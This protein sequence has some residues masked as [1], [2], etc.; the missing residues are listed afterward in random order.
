MSSFG[1]SFFI[2]FLPQWIFSSMFFIAFIIAFFIGFFSESS[3]N[4]FSSISSTKTVLSGFIILLLVCLLF[5][6]RILGSRCRR[7]GLLG[8][9]LFLGFLRGSS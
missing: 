6:R 7:C 9:R 1:I 4:V 5:F 3:L 8:R 2:T